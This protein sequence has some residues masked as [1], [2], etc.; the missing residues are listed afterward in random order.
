MLNKI[1]NLHNFICMTLKKGI[2]SAI[3][4]VITH[5]VPHVFIMYPTFIYSARNKHMHVRLWSINLIICRH[6]I[7][8]DVCNMPPF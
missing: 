7:S 4:F 5:P 1:I 2:S 6:Q 8:F 3:E